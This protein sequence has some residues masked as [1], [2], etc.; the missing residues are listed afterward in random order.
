VY[1][2]RR[3]MIEDYDSPIVTQLESIDDDGAISKGPF[4]KGRSINAPK[5]RD[6]RTIG[7]ALAVS[8]D[9]IG[10]LD[11]DDIARR[12]RI[13]RDDAIDAL[14]DD[15]TAVD[16]ETGTVCPGVRVSA[17]TDDIAVSWPTTD[18]EEGR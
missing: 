18:E 1:I 13:S 6:V 9:E 16:P 10:R 17:P 2:N 5:P 3:L 7:D 4:L 15:L 14:G 11:L 12:L 8:L